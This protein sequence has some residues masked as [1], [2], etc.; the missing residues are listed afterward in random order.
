[1]PDPPK[2]MREERPLSQTQAQT[3][4]GCLEE[5]V[6]T[7]RA[8]IVEQDQQIERMHD[9]LRRSVEGGRRYNDAS[10]DLL[11]RIR[12]RLQ[13]VGLAEEA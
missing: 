12:D 13:R 11:A 6:M 2:P 1:M 10:R 9:E 8:R 7:Q 4:I 3:L 5:I